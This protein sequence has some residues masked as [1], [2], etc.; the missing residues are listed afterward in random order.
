M[1]KL[2]NG[3]GIRASLKATFIIIILILIIPSVISMAVSAYYARQ[4][5]KMIS[6]VAF[7][8]SLNQR[9][10][11]DVSNEIW[12]IVVGHN[13]FAEGRQYELIDGINAD[14]QKLRDSAISSQSAMRL[15]VAR[16]AMDTL[17]SYVDKE[18]ELILRDSLIS[19]REYTLEEIRSVSQLVYDMILEFNVEEIIASEAVSARMQGY[20]TLIT[21]LQLVLLAAAAIFAAA[22]QTTL[23]RRITDPIMELEQL[24]TRIAGGELTARAA[25][26]NVE[27]LEQLTLNLNFMAGKIKE[28]F[29]R[30][31]QEQK[32]LQKSEMRALQAQITPHFLYNTLDTIVWLAE[33]GKQEAVIAVTR[34]FSRFF[35]V[36]LS[37]GR[38]WIT[39][40]EEAEHVKS[41]L[42]IQKTRYRDILD[43]TIDFDPE[44]AEFPMLKLVLQP[45]V[46]NALYHGIKHKRG[47]GHI[48]VIGTMDSH[49]VN[50]TVSDDGIGMTPEQL[51]TLRAR[52]QSDDRPEGSGFGLF[53]VAKRLQLYFNPPVRLDISSEYRRGTTVAFCIPLESFPKAAE[54][55]A[56]AQADA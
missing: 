22:A 1:K 50:V 27:E 37:N 21:A 12:D 43:Y 2:I 35:R 39:M 25:P 19:E 10:K 29:D 17:K 7:A 28:L 49:G 34:A 6:N 8:N 18:G 51:E 40:G 48:S 55:S 24:S 14:L 11:A 52:L 38:D 23:V 15:E 20:I 16:R 36:S 33:S 46:E 53:N 5:D 45:L 13:T 31:I 4:Y 47:R 42:F 44:T 30:S 9:V 54:S 32:N 3:A 26:A 56:A 41:Y